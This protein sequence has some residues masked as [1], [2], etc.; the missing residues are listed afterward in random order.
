MAKQKLT[1]GK[2]PEK[3]EGPLTPAQEIIRDAKMRERELLP[4]A[5]SDDNT[6]AAPRSRK[7]S[8]FPSPN[9]KDK[10]REGA[11]ASNGRSPRS[12]PLPVSPP[13]PVRGFSASPRGPGSRL[14][15]PAT[16]PRVPEASQTT[17]LNFSPSPAPRSGMARPSNDDGH[18]N[19]TTTTKGDA[20]ALYT[21]FNPATG[22]LDVPATLL[23]VTARF[24]KLER[25]TVNH[26]RALEERMKDVERCVYERH[27]R[28]HSHSYFAASGFLWTRRPKKPRSREICLH[29]VT[30]STMLRHK[31]RKRKMPCLR[32]FFQIC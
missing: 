3:E 14:A 22:A 9:D 1:S 4:A 25:W 21:Q 10:E 26:V 23:T 8:W 27:F 15:S 20:P 12:L 32:Q 18:M 16:P 7:H 11:L 31:L 5:K 17:Q 2:G 30:T 29:C 28:C 19:M 6:P 13:Q 24:E